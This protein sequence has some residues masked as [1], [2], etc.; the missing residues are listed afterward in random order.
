MFVFLSRKDDWRPGIK[1]L[2]SDDRCLFI[3]NVVS[4][5]LGKYSPLQRNDVR[6]FWKLY[7]PGPYADQNDKNVVRLLIVRSY[8]QFSHMGM[9]QKR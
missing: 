6:L 1:E 2:Q 3:G 5:C 9:L 7:L 4:W 8:F